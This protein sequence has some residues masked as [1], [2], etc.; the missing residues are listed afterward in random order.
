MKTEADEELDAQA[1]HL[2]RELITLTQEKWVGST[3]FTDMADRQQDLEVSGR[4]FLLTGIKRL[5]REMPVG[6][7]P[8]AEARDRILAA[9]QEALDSAIDQEDPEV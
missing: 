5:V 9:A 2:V 3:R 8:D 7:F 6:V 4:I 1:L